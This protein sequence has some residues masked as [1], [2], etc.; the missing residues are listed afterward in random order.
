[1]QM[2]LHI[3]GEASTRL[4]TSTAFDVDGT[5][6]GDALSIEGHARMSPLLVTG[7]PERELR[8]PLAFS[9]VPRVPLVSSICEHVVM[10][11]L[12]FAVRWVAT[13]VPEVLV[14]KTRGLRCSLGGRF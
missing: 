3:G 5:G 11:V 6:H 13:T 2:E 4:E 8:N 9:C 12:R 1:M 14:Q 7:W 10:V